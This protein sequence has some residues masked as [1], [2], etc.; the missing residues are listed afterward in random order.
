MATKRPGEEQVGQDGARKLSKTVESDE[1]SDEE[2]ATRIYPTE[3]DDVFETNVAMRPTLAK[4]T[5][6]D[7]D[8]PIV[9]II[10]KGTRDRFMAILSNLSNTQIT[11]PTASDS[12]RV[13]VGSSKISSDVIY[14]HKAED[15][16]KEKEVLFQKLNENMRQFSD[17]QLQQDLSSSE[18]FNTFKNI[19]KVLTRYYVHSMK[20][21]SMIEKMKHGEDDYLMKTESNIVPNNLDADFINN[22]KDK[23]RKT[24]QALNK[25]IHDEILNSL[26]KQTNEINTAVETTQPKLLAKAWRVVLRC[27]KNTQNI[28]FR[29]RPVFVKKRETQKN[30]RNKTYSTTSQT[31]NE[32]EEHRQHSPYRDNQTHHRYT[33]R[34]LDSHRDSDIPEDTYD[35][36][37]HRHDYDC[38]RQYHNR[39]EYPQRNVWYNKR[40]DRTYRDRYQADYDREFPPIPQRRNDR[41]T[42]QYYDDRSTHRQPYHRHRNNFLD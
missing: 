13:D 20:V 16:M 39:R 22:I 36:Y 41:D 18:D 42:D 17:S 5:T 38:D 21:E 30:N 40:T 4:E 31:E 25:D 35:R 7:W 14:E 19:R 8:E 28:T 33:S 29:S 26:H 27:N 1:D 24:T 15:V 2:T 32:A 34:R 23:L 9:L 10:S 11:R 3:V 37:E 6:Q 12:V